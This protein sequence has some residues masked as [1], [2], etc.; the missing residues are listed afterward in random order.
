MDE[1]ARH[2]STMHSLDQGRLLDEALATVKQCS[3]QMEV[4]LDKRN[5]VDG[6]QHA[7]DMLKEMRTPFLSPKS[8]YELCHLI[9]IFNPHCLNYSCRYLMITVGVY[10][11]KCAEFP[12]REIMRDLVEMCRGVQHPI[13]G[14]FLRSY[15]LHA[16]RS[17]LLPDC[18]VCLSLC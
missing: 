4:S 13:R 15:L 6:I 9:I 10:L 1:A 16:L 17:D 8:Y 18:E 14:L 7:A 2:M 3:F 12:R 11:I 5:I